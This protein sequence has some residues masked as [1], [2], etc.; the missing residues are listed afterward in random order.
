MT[1][2]IRV[3]RSRSWQHDLIG[4]TVGRLGSCHVR[5]VHVLISARSKNL[6]S[7]MVLNGRAN[8]KRECE[9]RVICAENSLETAPWASEVVP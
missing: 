1:M 3:R 4:Y 7:R 9:T 2:L 8:H 6:C 5:G